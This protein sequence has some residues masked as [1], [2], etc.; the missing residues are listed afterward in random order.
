MNNLY[1]NYKN[2]ILLYI[3]ALGV[4]MFALLTY[5]SYLNYTLKMD[6][7]F[8]SLH[9]TLSNIIITEEK[10][11]V[12]LYKSRLYKNLKS[13]GVVESFKEN[14][15]EKLYNLIKPRYEIL[16]KENDSFSL[17]HFHTKENKS[18]LRMHLSKKYGDDL[19]SFRNIVV[20]TNAEEVE[21]SGFEEG[22]HGYFYRIVVP[23]VANKTHLGSVEFG[24]ELDYFT[25]NLN[26][27]LPDTNFGLLFKEE[28]TKKSQNKYKKLNAYSLIIDDNDFYDSLIDKID[29]TKKY[30]ILHQGGKS[31]IVSGDI[32]IKDYKGNDAIQILF[33]IDITKFEDD[34]KKQ[35]I[36]FLLIGGATYLISLLLINI[37]FKRYINS[38]EKQSKKL[39]EYTKII[40]ENIIVSS[41]DLDGIITYASN[42]FCKVSGYSKNEL[43]GSA[44]N[45]IRHEDMSNK[46]YEELWKTIKKEKVWKGEFKNKRKDGSFYWVEAVIS[47]TYD[48]NKQLNGYT[49][50]RQDISN[51]KEIEE[52][53]QRDKLT[54]SYNRLKL[55]EVI[56]VEIERSK[57]YDSIFSV[58]IMDID[59]FKKVNDTYGHLAGDQVLIQTV[60]I[61]QSHLR[62]LDT[63]GRWGGEEFMIVCSDTDANGATVLAKKLKETMENHQFQTVGKVTAS[64]GVAQ[65]INDDTY[66]IIKSCD[67]ALYKAKKAGRNRVVTQ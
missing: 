54:Q 32:Y 43:I 16:K 62:K 8:S 2:R 23:V 38:I 41:T 65:Y 60:K 19:S 61:L 30:N 47:P 1:V 14:N 52:I 28:N 31:Y 42:A 13:Y 17:M 56:E 29:L 66:N 6:D 44:H 37:G 22:I 36:F 39:E 20:D 21:H 67:E 24:V 35:F 4:L 57:R 5:I 59:Y 48:D 51:R 7:K 55:D 34:L 27:L 18:F 9:K 46:T 26:R 12:K 45:V 50:I 33:A 10:R 11:I 25:K 49:A 15:R 58:I 40:D 53:S 3:I 64:F 63:L